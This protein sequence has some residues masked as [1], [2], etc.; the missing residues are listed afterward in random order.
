MTWLQSLSPAT[1]RSVVYLSH[2][3]GPCHGYRLGQDFED[4][5]DRLTALAFVGAE[6]W[7][8]EPFLPNATDGLEVG[9]AN[10]TAWRAWLGLEGS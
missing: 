1:C 4:Y 6:E 7:Q 2:E 10:T 8:L 3:D 5:V 9:G